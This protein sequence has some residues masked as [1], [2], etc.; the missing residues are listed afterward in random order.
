MIS[1]HKKTKSILLGPALLSAFGGVAVAQEAQTTAEINLDKI[2][3]SATRQERKADD[4][5]VIVSVI[6]EK[7]IEKEL[8]TDIKDLVRFEPG[9][10]VRSQP[11]RFGAALGTTG[12]GGNTSFN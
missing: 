5:P 4:V 6:D 12:R 7:Q 3:V 10:S 1:K 11:T 2:T 9:V 8:A